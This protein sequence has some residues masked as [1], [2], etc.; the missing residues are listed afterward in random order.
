[1]SIANNFTAFNPLNI[2]GTSY[3]D[4]VQKDINANISQVNTNLN[5]VS[6]QSSNISY[7]VVEPLVGARTF[8]SSD[9]P[10]LS[11]SYPIGVQPWYS[12]PYPYGIGVQT[13]A[14]ISVS[15]CS[16]I[17]CSSS[18]ASLDMFAFN[19]QLFNTFTGYFDGKFVSRALID[20]TQTSSPF[21]NVP[22]YSQWSTEN[23]Q[24]DVDTSTIYGTTFSVLNNYQNEFLLN[25]S[26]VR[27]FLPTSNTPKWLFLAV[28]ANNQDW[29]PMAFTKYQGSGNEIFSWNFSSSLSIRSRFWRIVV[30]TA[31]N[32]SFDLGGI[33]FFYEL[34][35]GV[36]SQTTRCSLLGNTLSYNYQPFP[37][38]PLIQVCDDNT[39]ITTNTELI[40]RIP[41]TFRISNEKLPVFWIA[42]HNGSPVEIDILYN[43]PFFGGT[44]IYN[45]ID[46]YPKL[47]NSQKYDTGNVFTKDFNSPSCGLLKSPTMIFEEGKLIRIKVI[48][49]GS[50]TPTG[51][52]LKLT[53]YSS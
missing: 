34:P 46:C 52:G 40:F 25:Y 44:S 26:G 17:I 43:H 50:Y 36:G 19:N 33:Q 18:S 12:I 23:I 5:N 21:T 1:M 8:N 15:G 30:P 28:S 32:T 49:T 22:G 53:I 42:Q 20:R 16:S 2:D 24:P 51:K 14:T 47:V 41:I 35:V 39:T 3:L 31:S 11:I 7:P 10:N 9:N 38:I 45:G 6:V 27:L 48:S 29:I 37:I 4:S 13:K